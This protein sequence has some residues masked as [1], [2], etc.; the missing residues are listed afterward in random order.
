M[1]GITD[2]NDQNEWGKNL[3]DS[4]LRPS[5]P[6]KNTECPC[7]GD[8]HGRQGQGGKDQRPAEQHKNQTD[9]EH[10]K[11]NQP[12]RALVQISADDEIQNRIAT[13]VEGEALLFVGA[14]CFEHRLA[15]R[16]ARFVAAVDGLNGDDLPFREG[17]QLF[18][19]ELFGEQG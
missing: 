11:R 10:G 19:L 4:V 7:E 1:H 2:T 12:S 14:N 3:Q 5:Q 9:Y 15:D 13:E 8:P 6:P 16:G 18:G 17:G